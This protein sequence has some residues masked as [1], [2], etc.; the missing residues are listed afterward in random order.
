M[1]MSDVWHLKRLVAC[2]VALAIVAVAEPAHLFAETQQLDTALI[3]SVDVSNSVDDA[4]YKLQMEGIAQALEDPSVIDAIIGGPNGGILF[5][6]VTWADKPVIALPWAKITSAVEALAVA[7]KVRHLPL[8][9]GDF[10]C[11]TRML[12]MANDKIVPQIPTRV[13]R[14][15]IDVSGDGRDNCNADEKIDTIRDELVLSGVT[16]NG[17]PILLGDE[18]AGRPPPTAQV[19][20]PADPSGLEAWYRGHVQGGNGSFV[21]PA[22]GYEDFARAIRQKFVI[23]ISG[24]PYPQHLAKAGTGATLVR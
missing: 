18:Q 11:V 10:T 4:R 9:G 19:A 21:L 20:S 16:I 24:A 5:S 22:H 14:T 23:E 8:Q 17:L 7:A 2:V 1:G 3:V 15:V 12:R 6:L 13:L